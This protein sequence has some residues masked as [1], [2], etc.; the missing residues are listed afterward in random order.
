MEVLLV[1][2]QGL[3][4]TEDVRHIATTHRPIHKEEPLVLV[5]LLALWRFNRCGTVKQGSEGTQSGLKIL[6]AFGHPA[7]RVICISPMI[8]AN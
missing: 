7:I 8:L 4:S 5:D 2:Y 3:V 6:K 1:L